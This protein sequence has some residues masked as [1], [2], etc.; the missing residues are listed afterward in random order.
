MKNLSFYTFAIALLLSVTTLKLSAQD[1]LTGTV[2]Y[3]QVTLHNFESLLELRDTPEMRAWLETLPEESTKFHR[4]YF[5]SE[6][7]LFEEDPAETEAEAPGLQR[8]LYA[9]NSRKPPQPDLNKVFY[10][11]IKNEKL[12]QVEFLTREF[13]IESD[14]E[15]KP[16]KLTNEKKKILDYTCMSAEIV[17]EEKKI[18]AWFTP[19]IPVSIGPA[20]FSGLPGI[21]LAVEKSGETIFLASSIDLLPPSDEVLS[22]PDKGTKVTQ[23]EFEKI[24]EEKK[25]EWQETGGDQRGKVR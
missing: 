4:L 18:I 1:D 19:E 20:N 5:N 17:I 22:K 2:K 3:Q 23:K 13:L 8:A 9:T 7:A 15:S 25:V 14:I 10:D 21:V 12:D 24:V 6:K 16:W 11:F